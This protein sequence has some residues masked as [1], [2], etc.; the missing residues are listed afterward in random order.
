MPVV[1]FRGFIKKVRAEFEMIL[2]GGYV[3]ADKDTLKVF[4]RDCLDMCT[5]QFEEDILKENLQEE[6]GLYFENLK[7]AE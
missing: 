4:L 3:Y 2:N 5:N 6:F 7:E 1:E